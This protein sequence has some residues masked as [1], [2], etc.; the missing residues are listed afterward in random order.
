MMAVVH[1]CCGGNEPGWSC[2]SVSASGKEKENALRR[3]ATRFIGAIVGSLALG[4]GGEEPFIRGDV[5]QSGDVSLGDAFVLS[6]HLFGS[7][8][9]LSCRDA[10]DV[11]DDGSINLGDVLSILGYCI[12]RKSQPPPPFPLPGDD[13]TDDTIGCQSYFEVPLVESWGATLGVSDVDLPAGSSAPAQVWLDALGEVGGV[14]FSLRLAEPLKLQE[15]HPAEELL[16]ITTT[17]VRPYVS[18]NAIEGMEDGITCGVLVDMMGPVTIPPGVRALVNL[19]IT[20]GVQCTPGEYPLLFDGTV[21]TPSVCNRV[22][23]DGQEVLPQLLPGTVAV[24]EAVEAAFRRGDT[25]SDGG[26]DIGDAVYLLQNLFADGPASTCP[27][28]ADANDDEAVDIADAVYIL[29]RLFAGGPPIAEPHPE[30][31]V[32]LT[33][34]PSDGPELPRCSYPAEKCEQ[35]EG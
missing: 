1:P 22:V 2:F 34:N 6:D 17:S 25:N 24:R 9:F 33:P 13:P 20:V 21:A 23:L 19:T 5:N 11:E 18:V 26:M 16:D 31:G 29:Q 28:A 8:R 35:P 14:S 32:D 7:G 3:S 10:A 30:C 27:D 4:L 15:C 12:D